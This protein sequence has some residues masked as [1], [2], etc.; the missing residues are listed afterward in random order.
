VATDLRAVLTDATATVA[1]LLATSG[2]TV[3][4]Y[5]GHE[6]TAVP[7]DPETLLPTP[8]TH[9]PYATAVPALLTLMGAGT[10]TGTPDRN[11]RTAEG[12]LMVGPTVATQVR[13]EAVVTACLDASLVGKRLVVV[14]ERRSAAG[15]AAVLAVQLA[16]GA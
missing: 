11:A 6:P 1:G 14:A 12:S 4:L 8:T 7:V 13:D 2:T 5:R 9:T 3:D 16:Q 10:G 15:V